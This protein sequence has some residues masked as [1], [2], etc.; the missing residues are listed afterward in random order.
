GMP[1]EHEGYASVMRSL[2]P[3]GEP[4]PS[5]GLAA[6]L[7]C[8]TV[9]ERCALREVLELG[10]TVKCGVLGLS[11]DAP[12]FERSILLAEALWPALAG[13]DQW[14]TG[15][16]PIPDPVPSIGLEDWLAGAPAEAA[17]AALRAGE[18]CSVL[19]IADSESIA[20]ERAAVLAQ[21][22]RVP[23]ARL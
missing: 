13:V 17:R 7:L 19:V 9:S 4:Y 1:H 14:P 20:F 16:S 15:L 18:R 12:F 23:I 2:N 21:S 3:R 11:A 10:T 8:R 6:Q 22:A 5:V